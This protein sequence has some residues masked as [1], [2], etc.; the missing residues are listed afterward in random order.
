MSKRLAS[1]LLVLCLCMAGC[2]SQAVPESSAVAVETD[3]VA[4]TTT[5]AMPKVT[6]TT[7]TTTAKQT[8]TGYIPTTATAFVST[9]TE[10]NTTV[11]TTE[12]TWS[13]E[14]LYGTWTPMNRTPEDATVGREL[15]WNDEFDGNT[16]NER[17]WRFQRSMSAN[18]RRYDNGPDHVQVKDGK[19]ILTA[20]R[21]TE[22]NLSLPEGLTTSQRMIFRYGYIEI[23]ARLPFGR[24]GPWPSFWMKTDTPLKQAAYM[25]EIDIFEVFASKHTV[26]A[27]IHKWGPNGHTM[28]NQGGRSFT[29]ENHQNLRNEYHRYGMEWTPEELRIFVDGVPYVSFGITDEDDFDT[30]VQPGMDG[31]HDFAYILFNNEL[32]SAGNSGNDTM[33]VSDK[34]VFPQNYFID[35][36]RLYQKEGEELYEYGS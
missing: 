16:L 25:A 24:P 32:F 13:H 28:T 26:T 17:K 1:M 7:K 12:T 6:T 22:G 4:A 14:D 27:N 11:A 3:A 30:L 15:V 20:H 35:W 36:V 29:F 8:A 2:S 19:L 21:D 9:K 10:T 31:F 33:N 18:D 34:T 5:A 23:C